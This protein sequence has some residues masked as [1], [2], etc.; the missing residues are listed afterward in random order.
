MS[1]AKWEILN[2]ARYKHCI[3]ALYVQ[4]RC[5]VWLLD[6]V[7]LMSTDQSCSKAEV[8]IK[9]DMFLMKFLWISVTAYVSLMTLSCF[10]YQWIELNFY[11][12]PY[13]RLVYSA[14]FVLRHET[15]T[16]VDMTWKI[17][18]PTMM[19]WLRYYDCIFFLHHDLSQNPIWIHK[20]TALID[21]CRWKFSV[22]LCDTNPYSSLLDRIW[23]TKTNQTYWKQEIFKPR[24]INPNNFWPFSEIFLL[25]IYYLLKLDKLKT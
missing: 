23:H 11:Y 4:G 20:R 15:V 5:D 21:T 1:W 9:M 24:V 16:Q 10:T 3:A 25:I 7:W 8:H 14:T 6:Y 17:S 18:S 19:L 12:F 13:A 22:I 2:N